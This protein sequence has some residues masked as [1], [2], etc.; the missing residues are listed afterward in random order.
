[1][2]VLTARGRTRA[3][4]TRR[5]GRDRKGD[6]GDETRTGYEEIDSVGL[7]WPGLS[8]AWALPQQLKPSEW[9]ALHRVLTP[10][11]SAEPG[12]WNPNRVPYLNGI[13]DAC[14]EYE[15]VI[16]MKGPQLGI[17]EAIRN[18]EGFWID[19]D[20]GPMIVCMPDRESAKEMLDERIS[21]MVRSTP[22]IAGK[23][24]ARVRD[25]TKLVIRLTTCTIHI[26]WA[27]SPQ[28]LATRPARYGIAEEADKYR[29]WSGREGTP[30][31][32]LK[33]RLNTYRNRSTFVMVST[34]STREGPIF[35]AFDE[36]PLKVFFTV[37]CP[38]CGRYQRL[39]WTNVK[40]QKAAGEDNKAAAERIKREES[41]WY[42]CEYC[43]GRIEER[44]KPG[45]LARGVW[46]SDTESV[47]A[48]G[49][50]T[51]KRP[52]SRRIAFHISALYSPWLPWSDCAAKGLLAIGHPGRQMT[53]RNFVLAEPFEVQAARIKAAEL[54][55][56]VAAGHTPK[57]IPAWATAVIATADTQADHFRFVVRAWGRGDTGIMSRL[58]DYG[59]AE[60]TE[61]LRM[62]TLDARFA[63]EGGG[64]PA[65]GPYMLVVDSGG[66][67]R[68][69]GDSANLTHRVY[70]F[71]QTDPRILP[72]HGAGGSRKMDVPFRIR[73]VKYEPPGGLAPMQ[74][75]Y[76]RI[77]TGYYKD[78]LA[79]SIKKGQPEHEG[80][81]VT[82]GTW[83]LHSDVHDDYRREMAS[84]HKVLIRQGTTQRFEWVPISGGAPN[85]Y[86]D[87]EVTQCAVADMMHVDTLMNLVTALRNQGAQ[88]PRREQ[89]PGWTGAR[90]NWLKG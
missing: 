4:A 27:G 21:V 45:M 86:W 54:L 55:P 68:I 67:S 81:E 72:S 12:P 80:E 50:V 28:S 41:A 19:H 14:T 46:A 36:S 59:R 60:T 1:M 49:T 65:I 74:V 63:F 17:S 51:G 2:A 38:H 48:D 70:K 20:P 6:H 35:E 90:R 47:L 31:E 39:V 88:A 8:D 62:M 52:K 26:G 37:P 25:I 16:V 29:P 87:C 57:V 30:V 83:Q 89:G 66:G 11:E 5:G 43:D 22:S 75:K 3:G 53:F 82:E 10:A 24:T 15:E 69:S 73:V 85:H 33:E 64:V 76:L 23:M 71:A 78:V 44:H 77:E 18:V 32:H 7:R 84:E 42:Q 58:L 56:K 9:A 79:T 40:W 13:M 34:P 61:Q